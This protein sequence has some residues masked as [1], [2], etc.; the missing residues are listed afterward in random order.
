M[1]IL[2]T[3]CTSKQIS[4]EGDK[5]AQI[6][7]IN[8]STILINSIKQLNH[9]IKRKEVRWGDDLSEYDLAI[10]GIGSFN[11]P[12]YHSILS[13]MY[14]IRN[15]RKVILFHE[16]WKIH[17]T[18]KTYKQL[19]TKRN[20]DYQ[21]NKKWENGGTFYKYANDP[22]INNEEIYET[23]EKILNGNFHYIVPGF[24]W[25]NKQIIADI[26]QCNVS[27]IH[28]I[29]LT[30]HVLEI[31]D[32]K[33][34]SITTKPSEK[35]KKYMIATLANHNNLIKKLPVEW[36]IDFYGSRRIGLKPLPSEKAVYDVM[37]NYV[38]ILCPEYPHSGS[39][40]FR[41][42][43]IYSAFNNNI[44]L[45]PK[46]DAEALNLPWYSSLEQLNDYELDIIGEMQREAILNNLTTMKEF[47]ENLNNILMEVYNETR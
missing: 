22:N 7:R 30:P 37:N 19:I 26:L 18:I 34:R 1:K 9:E 44:L 46:A 33:Q 4:E 3:G 17:D 5:R 15:A 11:S 2:F 45:L 21:R 10:V 35:Y 24:K 36:Q 25:G 27:K 23:V 43:Y 12:N 29:D 16:D 39:G 42:R 40:W 6:K 47:N 32:I 31:E 20:L 13:A 8:D 28:S 14:V 38:G 41:M